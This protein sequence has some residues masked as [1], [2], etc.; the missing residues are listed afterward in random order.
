MDIDT[1]VLRYFIAVAEEL[2]F[3]R[4]AERLFVSQP[5]LSKQIRM[6]ENT[7][8]APLMERTKRNVE[9]TASGQ[10][11]LPW[12]RQIVSEWNTAQRTV[13]SA[14]ARATRVF[15]V[16]FEASGAG[17]ISTQSRTLFSQRHPDI[18]IEPKRFDWG[19]E[20]EAL[21]EGVVDVA[22][23]WLPADIQGLR[24][25]I[26]ATEHRMAGMCFSHRLSNERSISILDLNA[27]P[28]LWT[29]R[30][31]RAW[32]DWWAVNPRPDGSEPMWGPENDNVEEMLEQVASGDAICI[33]PASMAS[34]YARK[35][36]IWIPI[37]D[38]EPLR[39]AIGWLEPNDNEPLIRDFVSLASKVCSIGGNL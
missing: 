28:I 7:L 31:P 18:K 1:R 21:R 17:I 26:V 24:T 14:A 23:I 4:A 39:I 34:Y 29:R 15:R 33:G 3:T 20:V 2:N 19:G 32:V 9:L 12:A 6:L 16:G 27:E 13:R 37:H 5:A 22:F 11:L 38:I 36:V 30:A 35:D 8:Q 25:E 10:E